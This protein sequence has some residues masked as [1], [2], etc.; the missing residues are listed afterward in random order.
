M[1]HTNDTTD[2]NDTNAEFLFPE[3]SSSR[4][5]DY[6]LGRVRTLLVEK[7]REY[8]TETDRFKNFHKAAVINDL[9]PKQALAGMMSKHTTS[10]YDM[11]ISDADFDSVVWEEK[12][13]DHI[14]YLTLLWMMV[15][16]D[17]EKAALDPA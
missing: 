17:E 11:I 1:T 4:Y 16:F 2:T 8:A 3:T 15:C 9:T 6:L 14:T 10:V 7:G 12:I 13:A 5:V